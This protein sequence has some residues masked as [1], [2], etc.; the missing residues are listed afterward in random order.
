MKSSKIMKYFEQYV[1]NFDM[2]NG[3]V[4]MKYFHSL[5]SMDIARDIAINMGIFTEE[6]ITLIECIALFHDIGNFEQKSTFCMLEPREEDSTMKSIEVLFDEGLIRKITSD[7]KYDNIIKVA[8]YCHNKEGL[9]KK[10]NEK[11]VY[12]C[13]ILKD[14]HRLEE[15][16]L[17]TNYPYID[18]RIT[19]YTTDVVYNNFK[20]FR[21][22]YSKV[23]EKNT[24]NILVYLSN[25]YGINYKYSYSLIKE[26]NYIHKIINALSFG[27]DKV[28]RFFRQIEVVLNTYID[29]KIS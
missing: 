5:K 4:K 17:V 24:D 6:E 2:N 11:A 10:I 3:V 23:S 20:L 7:T 16:R 8:I 12:I 14:V 25:I 29:K 26:N 22:M 15:L 28:E 13:N 19:S 9:P 18:N 21:L 1:S 27:D